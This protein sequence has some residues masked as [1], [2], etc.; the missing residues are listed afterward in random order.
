MPKLDELIRDL[1]PDEV[2]SV[3]LWSVT[4]WDKKLRKQLLLFRLTS[5]ILNVRLQK[6]PVRLP[7][8]K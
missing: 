3:P 4:I 5:P 7:V 2:E 8:W 6:K 1:C